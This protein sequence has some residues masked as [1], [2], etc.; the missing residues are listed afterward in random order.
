MED[1][2]LFFGALGNQDYVYLEMFVKGVKERKKRKEAEAAGGVSPEEVLGFGEEE[3]GDGDGGG[4][5]ASPPGSSGFLFA[6]ESDG[7]S[8]PEDEAGAKRAGTTLSGDRAGGGGFLTGWLLGNAGDE[9]ADEL[10]GVDAEQARQ[11]EFR[12]LD[13]HDAEMRIFS[14]EYH[15]RHHSFKTL[16]LQPVEHEIAPPCPLSPPPIEARR[17]GFDI[18]HESLEAFRRPNRPLNVMPYYSGFERTDFFARNLS[19]FGVSSA[20]FYSGKL[21]SRLHRDVC[22]L[23][24]QNLQVLNAQGK[25]KLPHQV[26]GL[27]CRGFFETREVLDLREVATVH[28]QVVAEEYLHNARLTQDAG[29]GEK[30]FGEAGA[31]EELAQVISE[32]KELEAAS[33]KRRAKKSRRGGRCTGR[34]DEYDYGRC[35]DSARVR[36]II[37]NSASGTDVDDDSAVGDYSGNAHSSSAHFQGKEALSTAEYRRADPNLDERNRYSQAFL[38]TLL[39]PYKMQDVAQA[40]NFLWACGFGLGVSLLGRKRADKNFSEWFQSSYR[41]VTEQLQSSYKSV[42]DQLQISYRSVRSYRPVTDQLQ[43]SY[44]SV[45]HSIKC[46]SDTSCSRWFTR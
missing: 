3:K 36:T 16:A 33:S 2:R 21:L 35:N 31:Q 8:V 17:V 30:L 4:G 43:T 45:T 14:K 18:F 34:G 29:Y 22:P 1:W 38:V 27:F 26:F 19:D 32:G 41:A 5:G 11:H 28:K 37:A 13:T 9:A 12:A 6:P 20:R 39:T 46:R 10:E 7:D 15:N 42:T 23:R 24:L 40:R 25:W 44:R